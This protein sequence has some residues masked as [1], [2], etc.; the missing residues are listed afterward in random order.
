LHETLKEIA[1]NIRNVLIGLI[2][3]AALAGI[4]SCGGGSDSP[5]PTYTVGGAVTGSTGA[6]VLKLNGG[7]DIS[8][9]SP[10]N[11]NFLFTGGLANGATYSVTLISANQTCALANRSGTVSGANISVAITCAAQT[12]QTVVRSATLTAAQENQTPAVVSVATGS[13]TVTVDP[14]T[15]VIT[16]GITFSG[17][18]P[19]AGGHHIHKPTLVGAPTTN[20]PVII[21]LTL[22][23]GGG[24]ATVPTSPARVLTQPEFDALLAGELY[25]NVHTA[26]YPSGE[27]RGQINIQ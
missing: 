26:A 27:I 17:L 2:A 21:G 18:T 23:P 6:V 1:V 19:N 24:S 25:F 14:T 15:M 12:T 5:A 3:P 9:A 20:G 8:V 4:V 13:G 16:G 11:G 22:A 10:G 7:G